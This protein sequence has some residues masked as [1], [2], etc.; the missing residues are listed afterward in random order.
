MSVA[1][2]LGKRAPLRIRFRTP[3]CRLPL[4]LAQWTLLGVVRGLSR[5]PAPNMEAAVP[6]STRVNPPQRRCEGPVSNRNPPISL[7]VA[8]LR[9]QWTRKTPLKGASSD[10]FPHVPICGHHGLTPTSHASTNRRPISCNIRHLHRGTLAPVRGANRK[11]MRHLSRQS[12]LENMS[13][14]AVNRDG[15]RGAYCGTVMR[16][17]SFSAD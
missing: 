3:P 5:N 13:A 17:P 10:T 11:E 7:W 15:H 6:V 16:S 2:P 4:V 1:D 14:S 12:P 8:G 9:R